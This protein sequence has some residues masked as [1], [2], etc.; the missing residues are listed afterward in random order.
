MSVEDYLAL[1]T[2]RRRS[3][4]ELRIGI[5]AIAKNEAA[6]IEPFLETCGGAAHVL[7]CDTGSTDGTVAKIA[8]SGAHGLSWRSINVAPW[9]FD[10]ARNAALA[11][12]P[13]WI[14]VCVALDL[15]ER[16]SPH[17]AE[18]LRD[19]WTPETTNALVWYQNADGYE[20][21]DNRRIHSRRGWTWR[22]PCHECIYP[23]DGLEPRA[24]WIP[25]IVARH[26]R[27][28]LHVAEYLPLLELGLDEDPNSE[29]MMF[30]L[31]REYF[32]AGKFKDAAVLLRRYLSRTPEPTPEPAAIWLRKAE[33]AQ[34]RAFD[35]S[36]GAL[37][38]RLN[39]A[40]RDV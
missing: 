26:L 16:L 13:E 17:W 15:D 34:Q 20:G 32:N 25:E 4:A 10:S 33:E 11:L 5:Y 3:P 12:V 40:G 31:G 8:I 27:A 6:N 21:W 1:G 28:E 22:Y 36:Q 29:R 30:Y 38:G 2:E 39:A 35:S 18:A 19:A 23:V 9:R 24:A 37:A 7:I 14:D